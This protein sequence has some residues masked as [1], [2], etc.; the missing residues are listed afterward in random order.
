MSLYIKYFSIHLKSQMQFKSSFFFTTLGQ[1]LVAFVTLLSINFMFA[2]FDSVGGFTHEEVL[3]CFA[4]IMS[5]FSIS[6]L[7]ARGFDQF[8]NLI[9]NGGFD[10]ALVRPRN[11]IFQVLASQ[12]DF[13]RL[14]RLLQAILV[15]IYVIPSSSIDWTLPRVITLALMII[16]GG[17]LFFGLQVLYAALSFFTLEGLEFMNLLT[18]GAQEHGRLPF[19]VYGDGILKFLT[20]IVPLALIQYYPLLFLLGRE[21]AGIFH[22]IAPVMSLLFL[23]PCYACF[24]LG[25]KKYQSTGS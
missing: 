10:R 7:I 16:C 12:M 3:L 24:K 4:I 15:F 14:G 8:P 11:V 17:L 25:L 20:F 1:F 19:S 22:G 18:H 13:S 9:G 23:L 2:R 6:E 5:A 21:E